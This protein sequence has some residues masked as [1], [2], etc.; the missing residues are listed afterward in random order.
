MGKKSKLG[1]RGL[2]GAIASAFSPAVLDSE[3]VQ[4]L[5]GVADVQL[6]DWTKEYMMA[7]AELSFHDFLLSHIK[8]DFLVGETLDQL[9]HFGV[10]WS[11]DRYVQPTAE[12][13]DKYIHWIA[14][15]I[16]ERIIS[17]TTPKDE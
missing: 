6:P 12:V 16:A 13:E 1:N 11:L 5:V 15:Y 14:S 17:L 9:R 2:H 8:Q 7:N 3:I 10:N 4:Q